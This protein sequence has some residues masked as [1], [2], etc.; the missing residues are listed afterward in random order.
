[1]MI[2]TTPTTPQAPVHVRSD[3]HS[4]ATVHVHTEGD[5]TIDVNRLYTLRALM[6]LFN[7]KDYR[8]LD[9]WLAS[10]GVTASKGPGPGNND[11]V[12]GRAILEGIVG[13]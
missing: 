9:K 6:R 2:T 8:T 3:R 12:S 10:I 11:L 1:M 4:P 7:L 5:G 13:R